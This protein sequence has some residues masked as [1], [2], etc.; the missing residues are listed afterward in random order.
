MTEIS[1]NITELR[2]RRDGDD[3]DHVFAGAVVPED[4]VSS[5]CVVFGVGFE[6][7]FV[8]FTTFAAVFM[9]IQS[10]VSRI[11]LQFSQR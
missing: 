5:G 8:I 9:S 3:R 4:A 10:R 7:L 6:N 1:N 2:M 11:D